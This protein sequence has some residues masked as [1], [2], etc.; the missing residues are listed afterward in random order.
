MRRVKNLSVIIVLVFSFAMVMACKVSVPIREMSTAKSAISSAEKVN[1]DKYAPEDMDQARTKL[2]ESHDQVMDKEADKARGSAE[3]AASLAQQAYNRALPL[4]AKDTI[5]VAEKSIEE[6]G[7][8]Y[9]E[10]LAA[11]EYREAEESLKRANDLFQDKEYHE[12]YNA[13]VMADEKA[14]SAR[15]AALGKKEMLRDSI[16][17]VKRTLEEA[18]HYGAE[19]YAPEKLNLAN[20]N[21][22]I[23]EKAYDDLELKKGFSAVEV[24]KLN[25][26]EALL[27]AL[28][29][30]ASDRLTAAQKA[31]TL[32]EK[33]KLAAG[34]KEEMNAARESLADAKSLLADGKYRESIAASDEAIRLAYLAMGLRPDGSLIA[35]D[36]GEVAQD[37]E[38]VEEQE[39]DYFLYT[40]QYRERYKDCLWY[41]AKKFYGNGML[42]KKIYNANIDQIGDPDLIMPGWVL[43]VPKL[44]K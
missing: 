19:K 10:R 14:K 31:I 30:T 29:N 44:K 2:L 42:W 41:I 3:E 4:I 6:A 27:A 40:V 22:D 23:A 32:A 38:Q 17:E 28:K 25:A 37:Q 1:A 13:A 18:M 34:K 12:A 7:E 33:S 11:E 24:A 8:A 16:F 9:A 35:G 15:A 26:D 5:A 43:K 20:E 39:K 21:V 36:G